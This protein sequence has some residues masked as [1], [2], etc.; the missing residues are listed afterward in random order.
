MYWILL[1]LCSSVTLSALWLAGGAWEPWYFWPCV[2]LISIAGFL[3]AARHLKH[4]RDAIP[5]ADGTSARLLF[6]I[7][8]GASLFLFYGG[9][10]MCQAEVRLDAEK[11]YALMLTPV[12]LALPVM[13]TFASRHLKFLFWA[14]VV[15]LFVAACYG[16]INHVYF[17]NADVMW[18]PGEAV[19]QSTGFPRATGPYF[20]PDHYS[21]LMEILLC[22]ALAMLVSR[23]LPMPLRFAGVPLAILAITGV[24]LS[25]SRGGGLTV[26]VTISTLLI[27]GLWQYPSRQRW[28]LR[29]GALAATVLAVFMFFSSAH[30]YVAR[31]KSY[32][33]TGKEAT[34]ISDAWHHLIEQ[35][36][37][38]CRGQMYAAAYRAWKSNPV[39]GI[40]PGMHQNLWPHFAVSEDGDRRLETWPSMLNNQWHSY[41]VHNDWLQLLQ[42]YGAVGFLLLCA[43]FLLTLILL[44]RLLRHAAAFSGNQTDETPHHLILSGLLAAVAMGFHSLGDFNLQIPATTWT[45]ACLI[46]I[47]LAYVRRLYRSSRRPT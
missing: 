27:V 8:A 4:L 46:A 10:R 1:V 26:L 15:N 33:A 28:L 44:T 17:Q 36:K 12:L 22:C 24:I 25:K 13:F 32:F 38:T 7:I 34:S 19:Y 37:R 29:G 41:E 30:P 40:G 43:P 5:A 21:G 14:L 39:W 6:L 35:Q 18:L 47:P 45:L 31:F 11:S 9:I 23:Q 2:S 42:E 20:C 16:I 3:F